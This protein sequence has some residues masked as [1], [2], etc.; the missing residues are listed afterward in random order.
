MK[1]PK[2]KLSDPER[3][4]L[5]A[6]VAFL[7]VLAADGVEVKRNGNH[8]LCKLRD[9]QTPSCHVYPP[10]VGRRGADGWTLKDH[11][12][13]W[14]GDAL[15]YTIDKRG[16]PYLDAV[17]DLARRTGFTPECLQ[18][19]DVNAGT[20][21]DAK[22]KPEPPAPAEPAGPPS[23]SLDEQAE[24]A[25]IFLRAVADLGPNTHTEAAAFL[26]MRGCLAAWP[27]PR[28][29]VLNAAQCKAL[30]PVLA[31]GPKVDLLLRAGLLKPPADGKP[32]R[33]AWWD[34]VLALA[35][36]CPNGRP[37][38]FVARRVDW[39]AG[40]KLGKYIN[41]PC[42]AGAVRLPFGLPKLYQAAD[43]DVLV[44]EGPLD[45]MAAGVLGWAA[46]VA[47]L[48][49]PQAH[50]YQDRHGAIVKMLDPHL[51]ALRAA[52][53]V[54]VVPDNDAGDKG[55]EG[56]ALAARL[57]GWLRAAGCH[58]TLS[59]LPELYPDAPADCKDLADIAATKANPAAL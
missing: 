58:A 26:D 20:A 53:L 19:R 38:Y 34:R 25:A 52:R 14:G 54:R 15:A 45:A 10:G 44:V 2:P 12:D 57:V 11:G 16:L 21:T 37:A 40:D 39:R 49:R 56:Q 48:T 43:K 42:T 7:D 35:C 47:L 41:Q 51:Q 1:D 23:M 50:G 8:W 9:E 13:G 6:D 29:F 3:A 5:C 4:R 30:V 59:T 18:G 55:A 22:P 46:A 17:A 36:E 28:A 32:L 31:N 33:L 24:A 27:E